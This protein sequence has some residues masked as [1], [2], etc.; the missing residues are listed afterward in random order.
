MKKQETEP[1]Q[2][3]EKNLAEQ[4]QTKYHDANSLCL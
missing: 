4:E 1:Q 3:R 2:R